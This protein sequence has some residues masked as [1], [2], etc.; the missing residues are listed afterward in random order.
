MSLWETIIDKLQTA[1]PDIIEISDLI[2]ASEES[3]E[4]IQHGIQKLKQQG[5]PIV[6]SGNQLT[7][8]F[9]LL[10]KEELNKNLQT[11][12]LANEITVFDSIDSTN[13]YAKTHL[14]SIPHGSV[15]LA[16]EQVQGKGRLGRTWSSPA[17][18]SMSISLVLKPSEILPDASLLTQL[19]AAALTKALEDEVSVQIKWPNDVLIN[20]MKIAGILTEAEFSAGKLQ[21]II[22]GIGINTNLEKTDFSKELQ[23]KA[24]S[25]REQLGEK[26]DPNHLLTRF[27]SYFEKYY[28]NFIENNSTETFLSICKEH[29]ILIGRKLWIHSNDT[30]RKALI[31]T[32]DSSGSLV[33]TYLDTKQT[34]KI[35]S[36]N[37]SIRDENGYI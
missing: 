18:K 8:D 29:S 17:G 10:S 34:E 24:T 22:I 21:G 31:R 25:L 15:F 33:V 11:Q 2:Q 19:T 26:I 36:T 23:H 14:S 13:T 4:T 27:L 30:K 1:Y 32:I 12:E 7:L 28:K 5:F 3:I 9:P 16:H 37:V 6:I 35:I 20:K